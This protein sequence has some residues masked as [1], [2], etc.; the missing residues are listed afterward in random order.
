M[1]RATRM[2]AGAVALVGATVLVGTFAG[3]RALTTF[4]STHTM[5]FTTAIGLLIAGLALLV[6]RRVA[7]VVGGLA[8]VAVAVI[9]TTVLVSPITTACMLLTGASLVALDQNTK[10]AHLLAS[11]SLLGAFVSLTAHAFGVGAAFTAADYSTMGIHTS[12]AFIALAVGILTYHPQDG[13][14][15]IATDRGAAGIMV[16]RVLP[17]AVCLPLVVTWL[18]ERGMR[19]HL[20]D[21]RFTLTIDVVSSVVMLAIV[22]WWSSLRMQSV[23]AERAGAVEQLRELNASLE[24]T[25]EERTAQVAASEHFY[26]VLSEN[27]SDLV[28]HMNPDGIITWCSPRLESMLGYI[29]DEMVGHRLRELMP[30]EGVPE[31]QRVFGRVLNNEAAAI[32]QPFTRRDGTQVWLEGVANPT[33]NARGVTTGIIWVL[34][35]VTSHVAAI[36][37]LQRIADRERELNQL[38]NDF[39]G[40]VAH[41][42]KSPMTVIGGFADIL[43]M[44]WEDTP[45]EE[46]RD[47]LTR[48]RDNTHRLSDMIDDVLQVAR[49]ESGEMT[50]Q[51]EPFDIA[52]LI[53]RT[54]GEIASVQEDRTIER[55]LP[56]DLPLAL[57]DR[58]RTWRVITNLLSN[59]LKFSEPSEP[60]EIC[61]EAGGDDITVSVT[62]SGFG[63]LPD[64]VPKLFQRFSRVQQAEGKRVKGTGLGL[65]IS[66]SLVE[67]QGG[68]ISVE[69]V[70][71]KGTTFRFTIP[72]SKENS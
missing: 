30:P 6:D 48:I 63:I 45:D 16:R 15:W 47:F 28:I 34:R 65:Y 61:A 66:K 60:V 4:G 40:I 9:G 13:L 26:R 54:A 72:T 7:R 52:A 23:D 32:Q 69:S 49:I 20:Y 10:V 24:R 21:E 31:I 12:I 19:L 67:G 35:D 62:D 57:G 50:Y 29:P 58:D 5:R 1:S 70:V 33:T 56:D 14:T 43:L 17:V 71:G 2:I 59:A 37:Q 11:L 25:V 41:D 8:A 53:E 55:R 3:S 27:I 39:V 42:L 46:R 64:D 36:D 18:A 68:H 22:V 51:I 44:H 38:K